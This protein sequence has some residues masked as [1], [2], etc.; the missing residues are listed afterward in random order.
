[1]IVWSGSRVLKKSESASRLTAGEFEEAAVVVQRVG[2]EFH[3]L[4]HD[5]DVAPGHHQYSN[6][7][8]TVR[9]CD[10]ATVRQCDS[11]TV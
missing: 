3:P 2:R 4:A 8:A 1:M 6:D 9:Q 10:S 5:G 7:S 11:A